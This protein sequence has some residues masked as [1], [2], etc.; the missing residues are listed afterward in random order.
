ML[1]VSYPSNIPLETWFFNLAFLFSRGFNTDTTPK[2]RKGGE[3]L[4]FWCSFLNNRSNGIRFWKVIGKL[5]II[6]QGICTKF[7]IQVGSS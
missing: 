4:F 1:C 3:V 7:D 2:G 6:V 5:D